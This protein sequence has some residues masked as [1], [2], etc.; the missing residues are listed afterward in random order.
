MNNNKCLYCYKEVAEEGEFHASCSQKFF[1]TKTPPAIPY[2]LD[3]MTELAKNVVQRSI[4]VPGVQPKLSMSLIDEARQNSDKRLTVVGA[5][6]GNYIFKPPSLD[7]EEMPAN[8]HLTMR[9][10][11]AYGINVVQSSLIRDRKSTRLNSSHVRIS[12]AV[13]CLKK[14]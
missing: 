9:I 3:E 14:K 2:S 8:E 1:G 5:L 12:Y 6:G 4:T 10:A 7:Y 11:E 13:F